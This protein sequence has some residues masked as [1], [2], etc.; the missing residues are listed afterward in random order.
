[1]TKVQPAA[2]VTDQASMFKAGA[3]LA[4]NDAGATG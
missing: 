3:D 2:R 1:M 4:V